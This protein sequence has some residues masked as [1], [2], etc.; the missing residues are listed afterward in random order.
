MKNWND[1]LRCLDTPLPE[2]IAR[3]KAAGFYSDAIAAIDRLLAEDITQTQNGGSNPDRGQNCLTA[4]PEHWRKML[5]A[6]R[7]IMSRLPGEY[8]CDADEALALLRE[9]IAD[10]T[11]EE[12]REL[13]A[14]GRV[15]WRYVEGKPHYARRFVE[16]LLA[17]D[18][19]YAL[20]AGIRPNIADRV[21][22]TKEAADLQAKGTASARIRLRFTMQPSDAAFARAMEK[23]KAA[24]R[25]AVHARFWLPVPAACPSQSEIRLEGFWR[26]PTAIAPEDAP[27][28]TVFWEADLQENTPVTAEYSYVRSARYV[29]PLALGALPNVTDAGF[30]PADYLGEELPHV[31]FTPGMRQLTEQVIAGAEDEAEAA[32]RIYDY[33]TLNVKYQFMPPYFVLNDIPETCA[34][35]RHGDCG[36]QALTFITMCRIA[37]I[38][39]MWESGLAVN[40]AEGSCHDWAMFWLEEKGWLYAD[41]SF[42]GSAARRGEEALRRHYFGS[43]DTG[44][45]AANHAFQAPLTPPKTSWRADPYDNQLGEMEL[46][47]EGLHGQDCH[48][49]VETLL[50]EML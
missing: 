6:Q 10:V 28:R 23:A 19:N 35:S 31:R 27:Q 36:V 25:D 30:A 48:T 47:G 17:T 46:E 37:G 34:Y 43:L 49:D 5:L 29:D 39:A 50:Y 9:K 26:E 1:T 16:T 45:F 7:E 15:D 40:A 42:G 33:V 8:P 3:M 11:P 41:C 13:V 22:R 44:R 4:L 18:D 32:S 24:G 14:A 2:D 12:F 38:P 21:R 20:R